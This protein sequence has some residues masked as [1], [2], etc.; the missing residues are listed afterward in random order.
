MG[1]ITDKIN[2]SSHN[3]FKCALD[4]VMSKRMRRDQGDRMS[5]EPLSGNAEG[6][7]PRGQQGISIVIHHCAGAAVAPLTFDRPLVVGRGEPSDLRIPDPT[8]SREH[9]RFSLMD[10]RILVEDLGS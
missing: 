7:P 4:A 5:T 2:D 8:L 9:A 3:S 6:R 1:K 10:D